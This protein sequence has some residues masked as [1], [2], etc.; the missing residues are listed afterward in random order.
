MQRKNIKINLDKCKFLTA[1]VTYMGHTLTNA[2]LKLDEEKVRAIIDFPASHDLHY[3]RRFIGMAKYL[4]KFDYSLTTKC[5]PLNRLTRKDQIFKCAEVQQRAFEEITKVMA[6]APILTYYDLEKTV[7][8]QTDVSDVGIGAVLLQNRKPVSYTSRVWN[9]YE[10]KITHQLKKDESC[11]VWIIQDHQLLLR[12]T[13]NNRVRSQTIRS[14]QRQ[15]SKR[16]TKKTVK[17]D[18]FNTYFWL[19]DNIQKGS[20]VI[21]TDALSWPPP[22]FQFYFSEVN[23]FEFLAVSE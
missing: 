12:K 17:N 11:C 23:L 9:D 6:N 21:I 15:V 20:D 5:E 7:T 10:K 8:M 4:S 1:E 19:Q 14:N 3:L 13:R 16:S 2:V 22:K 18:V